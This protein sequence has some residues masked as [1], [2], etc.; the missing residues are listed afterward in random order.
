M[1]KVE[2]LE[3]EC[4]KLERAAQV[5]K[6]LVDGV[7]N[8]GSADQDDIALIAF[9]TDEVLRRIGEIRDHCERISLS[10]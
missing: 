5:A 10:A 2:I 1:N 6:C 3:D 8:E 7:E 9:A 4:R